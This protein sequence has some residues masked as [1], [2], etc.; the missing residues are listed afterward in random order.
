M[1]YFEEIDGYPTSLFPLV[2]CGSDAVWR[3]HGKPLKDYKGTS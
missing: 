3:L 2:A 1:F